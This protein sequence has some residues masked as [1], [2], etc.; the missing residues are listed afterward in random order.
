MSVYF[1]AGV[2][3]YYGYVF[4]KDDSVNGIFFVVR[5]VCKTDIFYVQVLNTCGGKKKI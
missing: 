4:K 5:V 3:V 1:I 2:F